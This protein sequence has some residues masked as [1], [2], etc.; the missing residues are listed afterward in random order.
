MTEKEQLEILNKALLQGYYYQIKHN[1]IVKIP[2]NTIVRLEDEILIGQLKTDEDLCQR[3]G[4]LYR[5]M[6]EKVSA[7]QY[8]EERPEATKNNRLGV[9]FLTEDEAK[10]F[11][12][13]YKEASN[14]MKTIINFCSEHFFEDENG[15]RL[16]KEN[17]RFCDNNGTCLLGFETHSLNLEN[18]EYKKNDV[19]IQDGTGTIFEKEIDIINNFCANGH[20]CK[21]CQNNCGNA[22]NNDFICPC[23]WNEISLFR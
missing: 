10:E 12:D 21:N 4:D 19:V 17:C 9:W 8:L 18:N 14:T 15:K 13:K 2:A 5:L 6:R 11:K 3:N 22:C 16:C 7:Y 23:S 20:N 1:E